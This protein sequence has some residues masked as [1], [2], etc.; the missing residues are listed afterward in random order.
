MEEIPKKTQTKPIVVDGI[1]SFG[2]WNA[3]GRVENEIKAPK[4]TTKGI[5]IN[6]GKSKR[7]GWQSGR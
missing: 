5:G 2:F 7:R 1:W 3:W 6:L 4:Q